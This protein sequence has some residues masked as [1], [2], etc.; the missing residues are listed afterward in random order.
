MAI[1]GIFK[2]I[3]VIMKENRVLKNAT[4]IIACKIAQSLV[5][6]VIGM[7][8]AR[9]LGKANYGVINYAASVTAFV[10]PL[11]KLGLDAILVHELV[12]C[13]EKE[14]EIMGTSLLMN[15]ISSLLCMGGVVAFVS[16]ANYGQSEKIIVCSLY[17]I[18][19]FFAAL[20]MMQYW[21]QYKLLSKYSSLVMLIAYA[22]VSVY[23]IF[24]LATAKSVTWFALSHAIEYG[25]IGILLIVIYY[26]NGGQQLYF[27][28]QRA[29]KMLSKSKH[30][31]MAAMMIVVIQNTDIVMLSFMKSDSAAGIYAAAVTS[32]YVLQFV[33]VA[34]I[35]SFRPLILCHKKENN[36]L[37]Y[38]N[39]VSRLYSII[40]YLG[41]AQCIVFFIFAKL[42]INVLYG[43]DYAESATVMRVLI[44][45]LVFSLMGRV[46]NVWI[47]AEEKQRY[48]WIINLSGALFNVVLNAVMIPFWGVCGAAFASL[49]T[50]VFANFVLG[51]II[52]PLRPNNKLLLK[53]LN[54]KYFFNE[55]GLMLKQ[56]KNK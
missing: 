50:Q 6:F 55:V 20:E 34:I 35:D 14:G 42:I 33:Y 21:F 16:F 27:S 46:R 15:I 32:V 24:L 31:I 17:S 52:K 51:F 41:I 53:G 38:E 5:Q 29:K 43:I 45:Y 44:F 40:L 47:L 2:K 9:Y 23:K 7:I 11:M 19:V 18:S 4:W 26:K 30:Y 8:S 48:L 12:E 10:L 3:S 56:L 28:W 39:S 25:I 49:L 37:S 54:P 36:T 22:F 13:P 1:G